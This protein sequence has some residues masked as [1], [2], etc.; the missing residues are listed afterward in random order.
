MAENQDGQERTEQAT[1]KRQDEARRDGQVA[2]S[3][4]LATMMLLLAGGGSLLMLGGHIIG[5]LT[6]VMRDAFAPHPAAVFDT[7]TPVLALEDALRRSLFALA[8]FLVLMV[9]VALAAPLSIGGWNFSTK[10]L[11]PKLEKLDPIKG[12]G[13]LFAWRSLVELFKALAKFLLIGS[14]AVAVLWLRMDEVLRTGHGAVERGL[15][16]AAWL[17]GQ[18]FL[19]V[20]AATI[21][22]AAVDVPFQLWDHARKLRMTRQQVRDEMKETEGRPEVKSRIRSIQQEMARRRM[23]EQ[24]PKA[25]VVVTN[26]THFAVALRY[27]PQSMSAPRVVAKGADLLAMKI[28]SVARAHGVMVLSAPPLARAI[29]HHSALDAEIPA[30]LYVAVAQVL[31]YV[32]QLRQRPAGEKPQRP[33]LEHL[34]IPEALRR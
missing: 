14:V 29:Y 19:I 15:M 27:D 3:R 4:E 21:V 6:A 11:A 17:A 13:R 33:D 1:P 18:A 24:V 32:F 31:A 8:P 5:E 7:A 2:R 26:P 25:D 10:A 34:P 30:G 22:I 12:L 9:A 28:Q 20:S 23:M 16:E